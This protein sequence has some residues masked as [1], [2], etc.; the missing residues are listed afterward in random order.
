MPELR[1]PRTRKRADGTLAHV[2]DYIPA[3]GQRRQTDQQTP[4]A[5]RLESERFDS[6]VRPD[7]SLAGY[8]LHYAETLPGH[9]HP[10]TR[11]LNKRR[12]ERCAHFA[13]AVALAHADSN[14]VAAMER[15]MR[16]AGLSRRTAIGYIDT[17]G[18]ALERALVER[19]VETNI[20]KRYFEVPG[21][22]K[23]PLERTLDPVPHP[24]I[25][26]VEPELCPYLRPGLLLA[27]G[28]GLSSREAV[29][30]RRT[31]IDLKA[32]QIAVRRTIVVNRAAAPLNPAT[33]R[34]IYG[35]D[36]DLLEEVLAAPQL[37][38][39][40]DWVIQLPGRYGPRQRCS[41]YEALL[42]A[43]K[44]AQTEIGV[45]SLET[46]TAYRFDD[47]RD[48]WVVDRLGQDSV[49]VVMAMAGYAW[50]PYFAQRYRS[51]FVDPESHL[52]M[53]MATA[54]INL[55][56]SLGGTP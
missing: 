28:A 1:I 55:L 6:R 31:D 9:L 21:R 12:L 13:P 25:A 45:A 4:E 37:P 47:F 27:R 48:R 33:V 36:R 52:Q 49:V 44:T 15:A 11:D 7:I 56:A 32:R 26:L 23:K 39:E 20:V 42:R 40:P 5:A 46:E 29:A 14:H 35:L 24:V 41:V 51:A 34:N 3:D 22:S 54:G 53:E 43:V 8:L 10:V 2:A 30:L 38:G 16:K 50:F 17:A 19:R 18:P